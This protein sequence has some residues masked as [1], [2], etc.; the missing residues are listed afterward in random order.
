MLH[1][2]VLTNRA[3][4]PPIFLPLRLSL[5]AHTSVKPAISAV[6]SGLSTFSHIFLSGTSHYIPT[7]LKQKFR[8]FSCSVSR[9]SPSPRREDM[10]CVSI[11]SPPSFSSP[12]LL[13][14][15]LTVFALTPPGS[16]T[17]MQLV[18]PKAGENVFKS[19][20]GVSLIASDVY[21]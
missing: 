2:L 7:D 16:P 20:K 19:Q 17:G 18:D 1:H 21:H 4:P 11:A 5:S 15:F 14:R 8:P 10:A 13:L 12:L 9:H 3:R 6:Q